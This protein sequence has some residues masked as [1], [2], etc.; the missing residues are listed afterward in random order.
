MTDELHELFALI[1]DEEKAAASAHVRGRIEAMTG[2]DDG[3]IR[4][5]I[6]AG[7]TLV[8]GAELFAELD[9]PDAAASQLRRLADRIEAGQAVR[10]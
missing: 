10:H 4:S 1:T 7:C 8:A 6:F 5:R 9:S 3:P 2:Q